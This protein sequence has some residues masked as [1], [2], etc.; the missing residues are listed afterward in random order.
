MPVSIISCVPAKTD[1]LLATVKV[2]KTTGGSYTL[3]WN[4]TMAAISGPLN[5]LSAAQGIAEG[6]G[7]VPVP[8]SWG[9]YAYKHWNGSSTDTLDTDSY[10]YAKS[11]DIERDLQ[12]AT[13]YYVT[14]KY[15]PAEPGEVP[16]GS[17]TPIKATANPISRAPEIWW[18]REVSTRN[19]PVNYLG[20]AI[21]NYANN[22][23]Q[24]LIQKDRT[25]SAVVIKFNIANQST[26]A[27]LS[28]KFDSAVNVSPWTFKGT[29][30]PARAISVRDMTISKLLQEGA[31]Q[32]YTVSM[33]LAFADV[34]KTWDIPLPEMGRFHFTKIGGV[35]ELNPDGTRKRTDAGTLVPLNPDGTRRD[36]SQPI[37]ISQH[38]ID[39]Q[40]DFGQLPFTAAVV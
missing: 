10:S 37:L 30:Y 33:R 28:R 22:F 25:K 16:E 36:D 27:D 3:R 2:G 39:K 24:D 14:A 32:Y 6:S 35:Y 15:D 21:V 29:S 38:Q 19:E 18:D 1:R 31:Y 40:A 26:F 11:F 5:V 7:N 20:Y 17:S 23:H 4:V 9:T 8:A 12:V 13:R 34:G